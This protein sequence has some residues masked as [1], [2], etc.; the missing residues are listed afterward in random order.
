MSYPI[1]SPILPPV[2]DKKERIFAY[3]ILDSVRKNM[4]RSASPNYNQLKSLNWAM[5]LIEKNLPFRKTYTNNGVSVFGHPED[6]SDKARSI[7]Y[8]YRPNGRMNVVYGANADAKIYDHNDTMAFSI[9]TAKHAGH[10]VAKAHHHG[11]SNNPKPNIAISHE[12]NAPSLSPRNVVIRGINY[13]QGIQV[14]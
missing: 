3:Q 4:E 6:P 14:A 13:N 2:I 5:G 9:H 7:T 10:E 11:N 12:K 1:Q 8:A